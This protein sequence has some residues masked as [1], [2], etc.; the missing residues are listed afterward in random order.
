VSD[1]ERIAELEHRL[2]E[3]NSMLARLA[4]VVRRMATEVRDLP[5]VDR[6]SRAWRDVEDVVRDIDQARGR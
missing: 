5:G 3:T 4:D 1:T 2:R 6:S